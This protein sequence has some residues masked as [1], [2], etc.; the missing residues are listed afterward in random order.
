MIFFLGEVDR[1]IFERE[2]G[3]TYGCSQQDAL[4]DNVFNFFFEEDVENYRC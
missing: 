2:V 1:Q 3:Y 4:K